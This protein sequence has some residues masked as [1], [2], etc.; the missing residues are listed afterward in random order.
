[1]INMGITFRSPI[2]IEPLKFTWFDVKLPE[3][4][5]HE[6]I[7]R[8][9]ACLICGSDLH[10][11]KGL[12]PFAPLPACCGHEV[13]AEVVE[14]GSEVTSLKVGDRVYVLGSGSD[15]IPCGQCFN[16]VRGETSK[17][18]NAHVTTSFHVGGKKVAR[19]PSGFGS[20]TMGHEGSAYRLP[21]NVSYYEAATITDLAYVIGVIRRS[22]AKVG[23]SA[24]ILGAGPIGLRALEVAKAAGIYPLIVSEPFS[25]RAKMAYELG[26]DYVIDP[27]K[28]DAVR[29]VLELSG[30]SGVDFVYDTVGNAEVTKKGLDILKIEIG[31]SGTYCVMGLFEDPKL[32]I[33]VSDLMHK[34][35]R[36]VAE[37]GISIRKDVDEAIT[38]ISQG[39]V[40]VS[41]WIT[42]K[43]PEDMS[44]EAMMMLIKKEEN[45]I[46]V[47]IVH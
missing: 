14:I 3:P 18:F 26:A 19:F 39:K 33:N 35:G 46:G 21:D 38:M 17:C 47:E 1:M 27:V 41:K 22:G 7:F 23:D 29:R 30:G 2:V 36:I 13:A 45:A 37:W 31:G 12:H 6:A 5:P 24:V 20:Y 11:Y 44:D 32:T 10:V 34:A 28:E 8:I 15:P 40:H 42:H 16:C 9:K 43:L 4:A 25:Y